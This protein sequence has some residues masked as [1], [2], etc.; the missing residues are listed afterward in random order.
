MVDPLYLEAHQG[1]EPREEWTR[2]LHGSKPLRICVQLKSNVSQNEIE[3]FGKTLPDGAVK[4]EYTRSLPE[5]LHKAY[6]VVGL[7]G[8]EREVLMLHPLV[9]GVQPFQPKFNISLAFD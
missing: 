6:W 7:T 1:D 8:N 4:E 9:R 5:D 3:G 2:D